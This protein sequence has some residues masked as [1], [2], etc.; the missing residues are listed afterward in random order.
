MQAIIDFVT[1]TPKPTTISD[2]QRWRDH[3]ISFATIAIIVMIIAVGIVLLYY[4]RT[5]KTAGT[6]ITIAIPSMK[7]LEA[8]QD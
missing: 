5:K 4:I 1:N 7:A 6:H 2:F 3:P 8:L